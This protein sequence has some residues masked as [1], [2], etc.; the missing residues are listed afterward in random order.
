MCVPEFSGKLVFSGVAQGN[1][2]STGLQ[3]RKSRRVESGL[4][5]RAPMKFFAKLQFIVR[6]H[7]LPSDYA[8]ISH[9]VA[10][11]NPQN[12]VRKSQMGKIRLDNE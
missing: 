3:S 1:Y 2:R 12:R 6:R 11:K 5:S 4:K 10:H 7:K 9:G 8:L